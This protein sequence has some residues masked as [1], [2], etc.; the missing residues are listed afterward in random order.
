MSLIYSTKVS[1]FSGIIPEAPRNDLK[2]L[3]ARTWALSDI[4]IDEQQFPLIHCRWICDIPSAVPEAQ[5]ALQI[6]FLEE[7]NGALLSH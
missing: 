7:W 2:F 1:L 4:T 3:S 6:V 5:T